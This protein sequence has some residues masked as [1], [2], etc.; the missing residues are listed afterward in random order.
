MEAELLHSQPFMTRHLHFVIVEC[1][2]M[3]K[4]HQLVGVV[5]YKTV[6]LK[7]DKLL[8]F[9]IFMASYLIVHLSN[10]TY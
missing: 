3:G 7:W 1:A 8:E 9:T 5:C 4:V 10:L 6:I 2:M